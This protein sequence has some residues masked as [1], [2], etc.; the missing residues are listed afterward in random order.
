MD[1]SDDQVPDR[2]NAMLATLAAHSLEQEDRHLDLARRRTDIAK[3][4]ELL[5]ELYGEQ[6]MDR[7]TL[8]EKRSAV[9]GF[10]RSVREALAT[11]IAAEATTGRSLKTS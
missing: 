6:A 2:L 8:L 10:A 4:V 7:A 3:A 9:S 11:R 1:Y 5:V